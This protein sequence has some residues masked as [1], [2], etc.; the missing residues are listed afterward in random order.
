MAVLIWLINTASSK[1]KGCYKNTFQAWLAKE[2]LRVLVV[3]NESVP[4][5]I[6]NDTLN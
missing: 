6:I 4:N 1:D 3:G 2:K 5:I